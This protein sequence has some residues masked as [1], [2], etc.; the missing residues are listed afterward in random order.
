MTFIDAFD[1]YTTY[2]KRVYMIRGQIIELQPANS[3]ASALKRYT[4]DELAK[5]LKDYWM[6][7]EAKA[8]SL[9]W[10]PAVAEYSIGCQTPEEVV[11]RMIQDRVIVNHETRAYLHVQAE[12]AL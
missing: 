1:C 10:I 7:S 9:S 12:I 8:D 3:P 2:W 11:A 6:S 5:N 4:S